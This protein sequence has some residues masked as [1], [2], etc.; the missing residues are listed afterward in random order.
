MDPRTEPAATF[1]ASRA[2]HAAALARARVWR[3]ATF[4]AAVVAFGAFAAMIDTRDPSYG[5]LIAGA[6]LASVAARWEH[7]RA[8]TD[9]ATALGAAREA[10]VRFLR[11]NGRGGSP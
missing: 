10:L 11:S 1:A 5:A 3:W 4:A 7:D 9:A 2:A 8:M 6:G